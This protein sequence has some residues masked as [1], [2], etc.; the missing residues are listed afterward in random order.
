MIES[1]G[2]PEVKT[3]VTKKPRRKNRCMFRDERGRWWIDYYQSDGKRRRKL[4]GKSKA[5]A[6]RL[7]RQVRTSIDQGEYVDS[8]RA[9]GFSDFSEIFMR[10]HGQHKIS[11]QDVTGRGRMEQFKQFFGNRKIT[12][13]TTEMV[14]QYRLHRL[15]SPDG[16]DG[17][18]AI[19]RSTVNREVAMLRAI[20]SRA[21]KWGKLARNPVNSVED[22]R[23]TERRDRYLSRA[24]ISVLLRATKRSTSPILRPAVYLA[25][26]TGLRK[27]ELLRLRWADVDFESR[28]LIV[29]K[30]K[31]GKPRHV[32]LSRGAEWVLRKMAATVRNPLSAE[33]VFE[34]M[35]H[36]SSKAPDI[37][38]AW[39]TA[40]RVAKIEDFHF[41][42][43]RHTF[44]SHYIM[45]DGN[46]YA[47]AKM[48]GHANPTMTLQ[49]YAHLSPAFVAEQRSIMSRRAYVG[50]QFNG[51]QTDTTG[52]NTTRDEI[53]SR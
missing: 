37:T 12:S 21:V 46:V 33:W 31:A 17:K 8:S 3:D 19:S 39:Y 9:P 13:I 29:R 18:S 24:E 15:A 1:Y 2:N 16:R 35:R 42:D 22:Y 7:L 26:Q 30:S 25:L 36:D 32:V 47:L 51:H 43:L 20:L 23:G 10:Q 28:Q 44:A 34:S 4:A 27:G 52:K 53:I 14:E 48:L 50:A 5:D 6:D 38:T 41:H 45:K 40:L 49:T 11:Y